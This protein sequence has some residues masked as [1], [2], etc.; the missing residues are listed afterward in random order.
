MI[1]WENIV[2]LGANTV[3]L[4]GNTVILGVNMMVFRANTVELG[5]I[6][7]FNDDLS[8]ITSD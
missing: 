6:F 5:N 2:V 7:N 3:V 8:S 1:L 4:G